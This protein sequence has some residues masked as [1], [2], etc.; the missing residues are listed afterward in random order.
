MYQ[1]T[2]DIQCRMTVRV[3]YSVYSY[4]NTSQIVKFEWLTQTNWKR[5]SAIAV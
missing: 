2:K 3:S 1:I 4:A 5:T